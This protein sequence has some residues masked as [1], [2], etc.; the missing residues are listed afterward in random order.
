M[1]KVGWV[2]DALGNGSLPLAFTSSIMAQLCLSDGSPNVLTT[3]D[4]GEVVIGR[5]YNLHPD[6]TLKAVDLMATPSFWTHN[7]FNTFDQPRCMR[8]VT[9]W[10][11]SA[12]TVQIQ[13]G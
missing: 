4:V 7:G 12:R 1:T 6:T 10:V 8:K 5:M 2:S 9:E 11:T 13:N 3:A